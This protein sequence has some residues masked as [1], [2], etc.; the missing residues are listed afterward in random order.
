MT[1]CR[2]AIVAALTLLY[3]ASADAG[4][5]ESPACKRHLT[6]VSAGMSDSAAR[7]KALAKTRGDAR[8]A[9]YRE[10]FLATV[11]AR[12]IFANCKTGEDRDSEVGRLDGTIEDINGVIAESC[13]VQ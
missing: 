12:A 6:A 9:A 2:C 7:L 4:S 11:R 1:L 8:C 13:A 10:Q 3:S 5:I